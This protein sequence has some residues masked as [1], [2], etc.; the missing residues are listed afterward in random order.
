ME[1]SVN[2]TIE[3]THDSTG[4]TIHGLTLRPI[5]LP[6]DREKLEALSEI[7]TEA[8]AGMSEPGKRGRKK[9]EKAKPRP[10]LEL[11]TMAQK[12]AAAE[13]HK[14]HVAACRKYG[15]AP[16]P[17]GR[18]IEEC[19]NPEAVRSAPWTSENISEGIGAR[20]LPQYV[21]PRADVAGEAYA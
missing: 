21:S 11:P 15:I 2:T 7:V 1:Q 5:C 4:T 18:F 9:G 10:K 17:I 13:A 16:E 19:K 14:A 3:T 8:I 12:R 20:T 6:H